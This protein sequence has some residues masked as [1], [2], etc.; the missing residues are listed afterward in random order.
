MRRRFRDGMG[1]MGWD[2]V[3]GKDRA[4]FRLDASNILYVQ[5]RDNGRA[6]QRGLVFEGSVGDCGSS[7]CGNCSG[8]YA[9]AA[10][11][12]VLIAVAAAA[13]MAVAGQAEVAVRWWSQLLLMRYAWAGHAESRCASCVVGAIA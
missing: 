1:K 3:G 2:G 7:G 6:T 12:V 8:R 9:V 4:G 5:G 11:A 13:A 10:A